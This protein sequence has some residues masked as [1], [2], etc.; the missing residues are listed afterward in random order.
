MISVFLDTNILLDVFADRKPYVSFS[1]QVWELTESLQVRG[2]V[3]A[4]SYNN[5]FYILRKS[6]GAEVAREAVINLRGLFTT[7]AADEKII[8][9][10]IDSKIKDFEDGIQYF[11]AQGAGADFL[12]TRNPGD[13]PHHAGIK[14]ATPELFLTTMSN[15]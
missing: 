9:Q 7:V 13:F 2:F 6:G 5:I 10:A 8:N 11:S 15:V 14:I 3:S 1:K 4:I 12:L